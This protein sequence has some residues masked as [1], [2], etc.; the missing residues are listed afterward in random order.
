MGRFRR[1]Q[2]YGNQKR[3]KQQ[4]RSALLQLLVLRESLDDLDFGGVARSYGMTE[5]QVLE[6][7]TEEK[8][9]REELG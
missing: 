1:R 4:K 5:A 7:V 9:R 6:L 3:T 2:F 8:R